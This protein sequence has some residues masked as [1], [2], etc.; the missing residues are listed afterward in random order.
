MDFYPYHI[1]DFNNATRHL[2]RIERSIYRDLLDLYYDTEE[3]LPSDVNRVAKLILANECSTDVERVLNEFFVLTDG[4][5]HNARCD[6]EIERYQS[7]ITKAQLAGHASGRARRKARGPNGK[8][9]R[10][11]NGRSTDAEPTRTKNQNHKKKPHISKKLKEMTSHEIFFAEQDRMIALSIWNGVEALNPDAKLPNL[12]KWEA[13]IRL[14]RTRDKRSHQEIED[15]FTWANRH[16]FWHQNIL[17][18]SK[19]RK[20]WDTLVIQQKADSRGGGIKQKLPRD[21]EMLAAFAKKHQLPGTQ[22]GETYDQYRNRLNA[23]I[24]KGYDK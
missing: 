13:T 5:Y 9:E 22:S 17:S 21:N 20:Q 6:G 15:L 1:G 3:P 10:T 18:P 19:L 11:F 16:D 12:D 8:G 2:D 14:M 7:K 23:A 24:E 4:A